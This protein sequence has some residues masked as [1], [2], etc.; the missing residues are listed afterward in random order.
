MI[1]ASARAAAAARPI[2]SAARL[3]AVPRLA[4]SPSL[5]PHEYEILGA[6]LLALALFGA[7]FGVHVLIAAVPSIL[8]SAAV[9][10][11]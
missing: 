9:M 5:V 10:F 3:V 6:G 11:V 2:V 8:N 4:A 1:S 7:A